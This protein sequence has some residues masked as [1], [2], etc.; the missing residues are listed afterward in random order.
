MASRQQVLV[1]VSSV[2]RDMHVERDILNR[3]VFPEVEEKLRQAG[4][5]CAI[6]W[7]DLR[8][9]IDTSAV[10]AME[11]ESQIL[12]VCLDEL[13]HSKPFFLGL[14]GQSYGTIPLTS[15]IT[16]AKRE[17]DLNFGEA[18]PSVTELEIEF[19]LAL[20]T[21]GQCKPVFLLRRP[22]TTNKNE[23]A[24]DPR[25][26][27]LKT[28]LQALQPDRLLHY[29]FTDLANDAHRWATDVADW[30]TDWIVGQLPSPE[31]CPKDD[32]VA[33]SRGMLEVFLSD[34]AE[35]FVGRQDVIDRLFS[36]STSMPFHAAGRVCVLRGPI[37]SG[38]TSVAARLVS[39]LRG[40]GAIVL[41]H[42]TGLSS[43]GSFI[44]PMLQRFCH[45][46]TDAL[47]LPRKSEDELD[48]RHLEPTFHKLLTVA[49]AI[50]PV[51]VVLDTL[52]DFEPG[53]RG[54]GLSWWP[55]GLNGRVQLYVTCREATA[56]QAAWSLTPDDIIDLPPFDIR[57]AH[58]LITRICS[59]YRRM[60]PT[61]PT[62][63]LGVTYVVVCTYGC[64][65]G[66]IWRTRCAVI[67]AALGGR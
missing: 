54:Q 8:W 62:V 59:R 50:Q 37:G 42:F 17:F 36:L 31:E 30:L 11:R 10:P 20:K 32:P 12:R 57:E 2:F 58:D 13:D 51:A 14:L 53:P 29:N 24:E 19:A 27:Q 34:I 9:G 67:D 33:K 41:P 39:N 3:Q 7:I 43:D 35:T 40:S 26:T 23:V 66:R 15:A 16:A 55:R 21:K 49:A 65:D 6:R 52:D 44:D 60:I 38:K 18:E 61:K 22:S 64:D 5:H 48:A 56:L 25:I 63:C 1:F 4:H 46:L 28:R 45:E 47:S